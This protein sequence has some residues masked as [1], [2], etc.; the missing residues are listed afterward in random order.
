MKAKLSLVVEF[1]EEDCSPLLAI[2]VGNFCAAMGELR[3]EDKIIRFQLIP[4]P[5]TEGA[6]YDSSS[7]PIVG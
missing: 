2:A 3:A 6:G 4:E 7:D 1:N 5:D